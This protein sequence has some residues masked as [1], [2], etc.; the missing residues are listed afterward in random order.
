MIACFGRPP[1]KKNLVT[2]LNIQ[3]CYSSKV[4]CNTVGDIQYAIYNTVGDTQ[5]AVRNTVGDIQ[6]A[7]YN[8]V[9]DTQYAVCNKWVI[10]SM[11]YAIQW[12]QYS[13]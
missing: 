8:T 9:G 4:V 6:Y 1:P 13:G 10:R 7:V 5:Y 12:V 11:Q 2:P 3:P